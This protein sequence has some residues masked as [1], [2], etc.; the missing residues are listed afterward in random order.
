MCASQ[1]P[2][3]DQWSTIAGARSSRASVAHHYYYYYFYY[4]YYSVAHDHQ[5]GQGDATD[6]VAGQDSHYNAI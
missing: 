3:C 2:A 4:Y 5:D 1:N 6:K